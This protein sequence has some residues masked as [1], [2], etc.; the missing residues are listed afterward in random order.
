MAWTNRN[1]GLRCYCCGNLVSYSYQL[2]ESVLVVDMIPGLLRARNQ[3]K[4][5]LEEKCMLLRE[6]EKL[7]KNLMEALLVNK[8]AHLVRNYSLDALTNALSRHP[9]DV[10]SSYLDLEAKLTIPRRLLIE[11]DA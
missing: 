9:C 3:L 11:L 7:V 6:N 5:D 8:R 1:P 10:M 2:I 4:E